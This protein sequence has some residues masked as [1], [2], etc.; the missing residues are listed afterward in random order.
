MYEMYRILCCHF[1]G[2]STSMV[3]FNPNQ[4]KS[5]PSVV[6]QAIIQL[7]LC[8][9][10]NVVIPFRRDIQNPYPFPHPNVGKDLQGKKSFT[11]EEIF[12]IH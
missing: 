12:V 4:V 9:L 1:T 8:P 3:V 10:V 5:T 6:I 2:V 7:Q 11:W